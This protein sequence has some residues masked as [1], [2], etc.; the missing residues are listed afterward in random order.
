MWYFKSDLIIFFCSTL[1]KDVNVFLIVSEV[2][3]PLLSCF[4]LTK[5][6]FFLEKAQEVAYMLE[7]AYKSLYSL[8][9]KKFNPATGVAF[10]EEV[11]LGEVGGQH[12]E[13]YFLH[14]LTK[15]NVFSRRFMEIRQQLV[16]LPKPK[17]GLYLSELD[18]LSVEWSDSTST[19]FRPSST[20]YSYLVK[21][22]FQSGG[23]DQQALEMYQ[24][25][26]QAANRNFMFNTSVAD[27]TVQIIFN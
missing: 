13:Y 24:Q 11:F 9:F 12:L 6:V 27:L 18:I 17:K 19:F 3:G 20:F 7:P 15:K 4:A 10:G 23:A 21:A 22:Y 5:D 2:L 25:A 1:N 16:R 14:S 26:I 8:P